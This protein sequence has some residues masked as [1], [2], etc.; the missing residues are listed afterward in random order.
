MVEV[1]GHSSC[2]FVREEE[3]RRGFGLGSIN[4]ARNKEGD[5]GLRD[6][7]GTSVLKC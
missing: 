3:D 4:R 2:L 7:G 6:G 5:R 1:A